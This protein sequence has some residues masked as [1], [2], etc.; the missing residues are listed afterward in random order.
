[1]S[2]PVHKP[3][4]PRFKLEPNAPRLMLG[5]PV[6]KTSPVEFW[7][8]MLQ[9][10]PPLNVR[11]SYCYQKGADAKGGKLPAEARN[12]ILETALRDGIEYVLFL[13]DDVLFPEMAIQRLWVNMAKHPEAACITGVYV[14]KSDPA[15]PLLYANEMDGAYWDWAL[16]DLLPIH[17]AGAGI[18]IVRMETVAKIAPPWFNDVIVETNASTDGYLQRNTWGHDRYFHIR[19]RE[20]GG[21]VVYVDTGILCA[22][23]DTEIQKNYIM[24]PDAP[25]FQRP[26]AGEAFVPYLDEGG[27]V[28]WRRLVPLVTPK[29]KHFKGWLDWLGRPE[30]GRDL[31]QM[32]PAAELASL[33]T[34]PLVGEP[35]PV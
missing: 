6:R 33:T 30:S 28:Q 22:H 27:V 10:L 20:E 35:E 1:M 29:D 23:W 3:G 16:G 26:M 25:C 2:D 32:L 12:A 18:Q 4:R 14:S 19:L 15:E 8:S 7:V 34:A 9:M 13:D 17:S 5:L 31:L 21:G 11:M 24:P